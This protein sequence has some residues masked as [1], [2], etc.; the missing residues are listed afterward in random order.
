MS[1]LTSSDF[2][3]ALS[4]NS[5]KTCEATFPF[6]SHDQDVEM[7]M[8]FIDAYFESTGEELAKL[9][10]ALEANDT[11]TVYIKSH[12]IKGAARYV[13]ALKVCSQFL[14]VFHCN[15]FSVVF[16]GFQRTRQIETLLLFSVT[17]EANFHCLCFSGILKPLSIIWAFPTVALHLFSVISLED[18]E[19]HVPLWHFHDQNFPSAPPSQFQ[20]FHPTI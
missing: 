18:P 2:V 19:R 4:E 5:L 1:S 11:Q 14:W 10:A 9:E 7:Q 3:K 15:V 6:Y 16:D 13:G 12:S 17:R 20:V 8:E